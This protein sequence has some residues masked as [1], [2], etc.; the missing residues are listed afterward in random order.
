[1]AL[2][3]NC[4]SGQRIYQP[5]FK[6]DYPLAQEVSEYRS[7]LLHKI[8]LSYCKALERLSLRVRP[9]MAA[10]FLVGGGGFCLGLLDPV[11]NIVANTLFSYGRAVGE[12]RSECDEL[13]YIP[14]EKL[15]DLEHRSLDGM[16]TFLT[17]FFPYLADAEAVR[18]L[19]YA[20][21][22][23][24]VAARIVAFDI[25]M[26]RF[27]SSGPDIVNEALEMAL[28]CAAL[29]AKHPN[30]DRLVADWLATITRLDDAVRHLA[31]V[32]RRSPQSSLDKLAELL[33]EGS[34]PAVDDDRWGPW[35]LVDSRLPPPRSVPYWQSP[36]LKA[37]LQDA[38]H[39]F[40]LKALARL[41]AGEL[42]RR[43]HRSLLEAGHCYG[44]FDPVSNIIINTIWY[45]AAFPPTFELELDVIG[46][47]GLHRIENRSLYGI[48]SFLCTRY[49]H[50]DFNQ[51]I[52]YLV[53]ADGYLLLADL[54]LDDEAAG[55]TTTVDSPPLT[56]L[57]E[58]FMAAATAACHP[59]PDA[60]AKV[61]LLCSS[62]QMLEDASSLLHG[63]GQLSS[64]DVQ[65][66]VRLLCPEATCSKQPLRPFP[67]P[68]YLFAHTRMSKK[69]P[70]YELHTIC[71]V[72][73][74]VSGPVGTDAKCFRSHVNFLATPKGTPFSTYSNPV[75]FF[76]EV[77]N[78]NKAEAGTQ[79]F[80]CLVSVPL[81]CAER[82]RCLY[83]DDMGIKIVHPIGVDFH[84]R[85]L[86]FEKMVCGEDPCNDDFDP[87]SMQPYYTNMS[88]IEHSSLTTDRVNGRVE[89]DR[90]YSDEYDS[91]DL[92]LMSDEYDSDLCS[93]TDEYD[94]IYPKI[95]SCCRHY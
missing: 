21:A 5:S 61:L 6:R 36:A 53:N 3:P 9:R 15:R 81:P 32:H 65:L 75:L 38:I 25:G 41:P 72:N 70:M 64:E 8:H 67:R 55:F 47:M 7:R 14:E 37:T 23:L 48:V 24:L 51:A 69:E 71:G 93:M 89:E 10:S 52:K 17:R 66:L 11:S 82:V 74:C 26:R 28:K 46:T 57:E 34:P 88:I 40:Y 76:A 80:C 73:N 42:R 30:P 85:K 18:F 54:Y 19:L 44:P 33:D 39:G 31:D 87:E 29:A 77:S 50:I 92:S 84:G 13:V 60:Q 27:G 86:E 45:D 35:R 20:E 79:S 12:T 22:D 59:D 2:V 49:H 1:M 63:G 4:P 43:F 16:V 68:E 83:C 94:I 78:D 95:V 90:L 62:G 56:G 58:A 91:D